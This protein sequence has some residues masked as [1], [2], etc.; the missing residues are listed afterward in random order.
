MS[1][2]VGTMDVTIGLIS[3]ILRSNVEVRFSAVSSDAIG[4]TMKSNNPCVV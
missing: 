3:G 1:E 4:K 2:S